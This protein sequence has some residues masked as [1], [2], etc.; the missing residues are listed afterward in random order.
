MLRIL[1][2]DQSLNELDYSIRIS[3]NAD[4][5][6]PDCGKYP[7]ECEDEPIVCTECGKYPCECNGGINSVS[8]LQS[9][10]PL[11]AWTHNGNLLRITGLTA[12]ETLSIF[13]ATGALVYH[14]VAT[15]EE[16]DI[17]L[18]VQGV[19]IVRSGNN[20]VNIVI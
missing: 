4:D 15:S 7:C 12:G 3:V 8:E 17:P 2:F 19:Y 14:S 20:S 9:I 6:C 13:S 16:M 10:N 5:V 1:L 18:S 11:R